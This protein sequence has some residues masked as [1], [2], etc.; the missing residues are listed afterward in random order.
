[1]NKRIAFGIGSFG[2]GFLVGALLDP[3]GLHIMPRAVTRGHPQGATETTRAVGPLPP[4]VDQHDGSAAVGGRVTDAAGR[5]LRR[6]VLRMVGVDSPEVNATTTSDS[7]GRYELRGLAAGQYI[8]AASKA[9]LVTLEFGQADAFEPPGRIELRKAQHLADTDIA[10]PD[11]GRVEGRVLDE[12]GDPATDVVV[13]VYRFV[14]LHGTRT[15]DSVE[16][17]H[18]ITRTDPTGHFAIFGLPAGLYVV[19]ATSGGSFFARAS[20]T[21]P[22]YT[23]IRTYYPGTS[24]SDA[25]VQVAVRSG[26]GSTITFSLK[27]VPVGRISGRVRDSHDLP[28]VNGLLRVWQPAVPMAPPVIV[29]LQRGGI[30]EVNVPVSALPYRVAAITGGQAGAGDPGGSREVGECSTTVVASVTSKVA[31]ATAPGETIVGLVTTVKGSRQPEFGRLRVVAE[32]IAAADRW[33]GG[34]SVPV[35]PDG[36]FQVR[37]LLKRSVLTIAA[38][39]ASDLALDTVY[40]N[41]EDVTEAGVDPQGHGSANTVVV[42]TSQPASIEGIVRD[43]SETHARS[44][45][46][47]IAEN[48]SRWVDVLDRYVTVTRPDLDGAFAFHKVRPGRYRLIAVPSIDE[49]LLTSPATLTRLCAAGRPLIV[50]DGETTTAYIHTASVW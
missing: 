6:A 45:V 37:G 42:L 24:D 13:A 41:G 30:F 16:G 50:G 46:V 28:V 27:R 40:V 8:L 22:S 17:D 31:L 25:A 2:L 47:L 15:L 34:V 49:G 19:A 5:P 12:E 11:A 14:Y 20:D 7:A 10:L 36:T 29:Q 4:F 9:G 3:G 32:P 33:V 18:F 26:Y 35:A 23:Y 43:V 21:K 39:A 48:R 38:P 44:V 1:M